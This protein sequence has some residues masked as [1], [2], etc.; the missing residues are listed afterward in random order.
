VTSVIAARRRT[1]RAPGRAGA[2]RR[3]GRTGRLRAMSRT[4]GRC[5]RCGRRACRAPRAAR[6]RRRGPRPER[7]VADT[8]AGFRQ[9]VAQ[10]GRLRVVHLR[11][12]DQ[13]RAPGAERRRV[14][15][16]GR[17][18]CERH[19]VE[20]DVLERV[21]RPG[22][23]VSREALRGRG[24]VLDDVADVVDHRVAA[25]QR[26]VLTI[27]TSPPSSN[28]RSTSPST[29]RT[30]ASPAASTA[31]APPAEHSSARTAS[32]IDV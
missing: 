8:G 28:C 9:R 3:G 23:E 11:E 1:P 12:L 6:P 20:G 30:R 4:P 7:D 32:S 13:D 14:V 24:Q 26:N 29:A 27:R 21:E 16:D 22:A 10:P 25:T 19:L 2:P 17:L 15:V 5:G 31:R 18:A